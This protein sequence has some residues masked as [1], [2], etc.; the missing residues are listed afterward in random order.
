MML[1]KVSGIKRHISVDGNGLPHAMY[2]TKADITDRNQ[3][4]QRWLKNTITIYL[5]FKISLQMLGTQEKNW[6]IQYIK[7]QDVLQKQ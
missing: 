7:F 2:V 6:L 3:V 1:V 4:L 5:K